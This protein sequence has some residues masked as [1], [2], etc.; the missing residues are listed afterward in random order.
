MIIAAI[1]QKYQGKE[2]K[3]SSKSAADD[4]MNFIVLLVH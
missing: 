2:I 4:A 3:S 1:T